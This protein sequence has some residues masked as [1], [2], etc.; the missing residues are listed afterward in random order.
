MRLS[1]LTLAA[2]IA[3][4]GS[5]SAANAGTYTLG[6]VSTG[7]AAV[8]NFTTNLS[9]AKFDGTL[10]TLVSVTFSLTGAVSGTA[11]AESQDAGPTDV[12]VNLASSIKLRRPDNTD[13]TVVLPSA[14]GSFSFSA[15]D[16]TVD[17]AGTSGGTI[18]TLT[19]SVTNTSTTSTLSDRILFTDTDLSPGAQDSISLNIR[20]VGASNGNGA[21]QLSLVFSTLAAANASVTYNYTDNPPVGVPEPASMALLGAGLLGVGLIRRKRV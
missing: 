2:A 15:F 1:H 6:P 5:L 17:Y 12:D 19:N 9:F 21:G 16:G 14:S 8:T 20:A 7:P 10:G 11:Q 13:L 18:T 4:A 3:L